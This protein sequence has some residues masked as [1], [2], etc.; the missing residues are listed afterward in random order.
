MAAAIKVIPNS[1]GR[2][3]SLEDKMKVISEA[4]LGKQTRKVRKDFR[5]QLYS[6]AKK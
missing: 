4:E 1:A 6:I 2:Y 5:I 3:L